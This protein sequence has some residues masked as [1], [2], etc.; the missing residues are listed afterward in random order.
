MYY[1]MSQILKIEEDIKKIN[2]NIEEN[3]DKTIELLKKN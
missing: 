3:K 1:I 2:K